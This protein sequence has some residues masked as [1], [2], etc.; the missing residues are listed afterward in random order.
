MSA[1]ALA[2]SEETIGEDV[3]QIIIMAIVETL[4]NKNGKN[5]N[6]KTTCNK[7]QRQLCKRLAGPFIPFPGLV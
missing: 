3:K 5:A 4:P 2:D 7:T 1:S 6:E